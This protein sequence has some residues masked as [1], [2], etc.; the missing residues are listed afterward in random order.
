M[1]S[2]ERRLQ[3]GIILSLILLMGLL[4]VVGNQAIRGL[5]EDFVASRLEHDAESLLAALEMNDENVSLRKRQIN[6]VFDQPFSGHYYV[7]RFSDG[8][9]LVS[10][11]LRGQMLTV[12]ALTSS[13][14]LRQHQ[15]GPEGQ[16]LLL[17]V[18]DYSKHGQDFTLAIAEDL[19]PIQKHKDR[20][21]NYF[22]LL[23]LAGLFGLLL[24]LSLMLRGSFRRLDTVRE[25]IRQLQQ[26][27]IDVL[28]EQAPKE[29]V[30][31]VREVN[32][33]HSLFTQRLERSR[34]ALGNLAHALK[35]PLS[36]LV[37]YLDNEQY[38]TNE[39][40]RQHAVNQAERIRQLMERELHRARLAGKGGATRKFNPREEL[41]DLVALLKQ[42][43]R[44]QNLEIIYDVT[45]DLPAFGDREDMLELVGNLMDNACKWAKSRIRCSISENN[46]V[47]IVVEDDGAGLSEEDLLK[48]VRRGSRLDESVEGHGLGLAIVADIIKLYGGQIRFDKAVKLGGL[49]VEVSL[50]LGYRA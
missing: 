15:P 11:S 9:E 41:S 26:G 14:A 2:L 38:T 6:P 42:S 19:T 32:Q 5:T 16:D 40:Q 25:E 31:L 29:I 36:I 22:A 21:K 18:K 45:D 30:P 44:K 17:W 8:R 1:N 27:S 43:H 13:E 50:P 23:T 28:S 49:R 12:P 39:E 20:F 37:Q 35:G 47:S 24:V 4:W 33:L 46:T 7:I 3:V 34:N 10:R 48:L